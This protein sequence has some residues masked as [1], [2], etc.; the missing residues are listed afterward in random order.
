M[1]SKHLGDA[2]DH[3]K[4]SMIEHTR[5]LFN[6]CIAVIPMITDDSWE[7]KQKSFYC[8]LLNVSEECVLDWEPVHKNNNYFQN[9][10][11]GVCDSDLFLDPDIGI[12]LKPD[13]GHVSW[14]TI[15]DLLLNENRV[16]MVY[17]DASRRSLEKRLDKIEEMRKK[18]CV[19]LVAYDCG[20]VAMLF[21]SYSE[22]RIKKIADSLKEML[23]GDMVSRDKEGCLFERVKIRL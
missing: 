3:W 7:C 19:H 13:R 10:V 12:A 23:S 18:A 15:K 11:K 9:I 14:Y 16:I 4:G 1:N 8:K 21:F 22:T 5:E 20:Q 6:E 2:L 17:Q